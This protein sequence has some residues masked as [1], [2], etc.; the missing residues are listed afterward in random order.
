M[1]QRI[2]EP[3]LGALHVWHA[4]MVLLARRGEML[5]ISVYE[6][7]AI[8]SLA[9]RCESPYHMLVIEVDDPWDVST[10]NRIRASLSRFTA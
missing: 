7:P 6:A 4:S 3:E 5:G 9:A 2:S 1:D 8:A 10:Q